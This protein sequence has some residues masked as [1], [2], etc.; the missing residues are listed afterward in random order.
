MDVF[1]PESSTKT[2]SDIN[3]RLDRLPR[4]SLGFGPFIVLGLAFFFAYYDITIIGVTLPNLIT[5]FHLN[6]SQI[7]IPVSANLIGYM[8]GSYVLGSLAD[9]W[10]RR[11]SLQVTLLVLGLGGI[12][13]ALSWNLG[14]LSLFRFITGLGIGAVIS[15]ASTIMTE[16]SPS[17]LRGRNVQYQMIWGGIGLAGAPFAA[18][19][20][21]QLGS[22]GWRV[23]F[24]VA[25]LAIVL[26]C[27]CRDPWLP[28]SPR[29]LVLHGQPEEAARILTA[30]ENRIT[31]RLNG[32]LPE[33]P[34]VPPETSSSTFPTAA[35]FRSPYLGRTLFVFFWWGIAYV[36]LYGYLA[37]EP[38]LL[39]KMGLSP[40]HGLLYTALGDTG[41]PIGAAL[42]LLVVE[43]VQRRAIIMTLWALYVI[44]F[45][46]LATSFNGFTVFL[47]AFLVS[48]SILANGVSYTYTTEIF[49][50]RAR[51][52]A[53][54]IGDG[55]GHIGGVIAPFVVLTVLAMSGARGVFWIFAIL[56][57]VDFL[58]MAILGLRHTTGEHLTK[59]AS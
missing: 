57:L 1:P 37:Y 30:M 58:M 13:T 44:S 16:L 23:A 11:R 5:K 48:L 46:I 8:V 27:F 6:G 12:L 55:L 42:V 24:G 52:S 39:G 28:E 38:Y 36:M 7:A 47:G 35:L 10:G 34:V 2:V 45:I 50:T 22:Y 40:A 21:L 29:W 41:I 4:G 26:A 19:P 53:I 15:L 20:L 43:R 17:K 32:P 9:V 56:S 54:S 49:P 14:S 31:H 25:A 51:A 18:I 3:G 59:L 33:V